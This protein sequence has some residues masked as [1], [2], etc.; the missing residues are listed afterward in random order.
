MISDKRLLWAN[1]PLQLDVLKLVLRAI[2]INTTQKLNVRWLYKTM[3]LPY[4]GLSQVNGYAIHSFILWN[5]HGNKECKIAERILRF[6]IGSWQILCRS[7]TPHITLLLIFEISFLLWLNK[8]LAL[9]VVFWFWRNYSA[10]PFWSR[11][12]FFLNIPLLFA[13]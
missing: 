9:W 3:I 8:R 1:I 2:Y 11:A 4:S 12:V 7:L 10:F 5:I 13:N 6:G